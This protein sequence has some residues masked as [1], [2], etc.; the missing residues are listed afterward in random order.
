MNDDKELSEVNSGC[1]FCLDI[2]TY[3]YTKLFGPVGDVSG[4]A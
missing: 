4:A 2:M 1:G 3:G